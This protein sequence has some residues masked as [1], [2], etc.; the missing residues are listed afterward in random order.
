MS[1]S[2]GKKTIRGTVYDLCHLNPFTVNV[3]PKAEGA[4]T[5]VVHVTFGSHTFT[6][7]WDPSYTPDLRFIDGTEVRCF[8]PDRHGYSLQLPTIVRQGVFGRAYFSQGQNFLLVESLPGLSGPYAVFFNVKPAKMPGVDAAMFI[9]SA[10]EK[11]GLPPKSRLPAIT[12]PTLI[13]KT[14]AGQPIKR[15]KRK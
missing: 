4:P 7:E 12:F 8:C 2:W 6:K 15:P 5:Y 9:V 14:I 3:T 10:Y 13:S 11:P 1:W